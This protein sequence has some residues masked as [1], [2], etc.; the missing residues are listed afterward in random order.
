TVTRLTAHTHLSHGGVIAISALLVIP[1]QTRVMTRGAHVV[2]IHPPPRPMA[3]FSWLSILIA[4]DVE[5]FIGARGIASLQHLKSAVRERNEKLPEW[6]LA[7]YPRRSVGLHTSRCSH[8]GN[9]R[10]VVGPADG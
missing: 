8:T 4:I 5:P 3:P 2:P 7:D 6:I 10:I 9:L 1:A